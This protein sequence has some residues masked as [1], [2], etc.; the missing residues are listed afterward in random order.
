MLRPFCP[1]EEN[2]YGVLAGHRGRSGR[3]RKISPSTGVRI[4]ELVRFEFSW[5]MIVI[6]RCL[7]LKRTHLTYTG[8]VDFLNSRN[9]GRR[10]RGMVV[11]VVKTY[12]SCQKH[13]S[14]SERDVVFL[15]LTSLKSNLGTTLIAQNNTVNNC[16]NSHAQNTPA[17]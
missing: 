5:L 14:L 1:W 7:L 17:L 2:R 9:D 12:T 16:F 4:R 6:M 10:W 13:E 11:V 3:E 8:C 15:F